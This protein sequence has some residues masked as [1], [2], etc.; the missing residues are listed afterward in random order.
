MNAFSAISMSRFRLKTNLF[1]FFKLQEEEIP[2]T[3]SL[4]NNK[5]CICYI[6]GFDRHTNLMVTDVQE[7]TVNNL[8]YTIDRKISKAFIRGDNVISVSYDPSIEQDSD[9][10]SNL[11]DNAAE[12]DAKRPKVEE[13]AS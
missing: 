7:I 3:I 9:Y 13:S 1:V 8:K 2:V 11:E 10:D 4:R 6:R 12:I 5:K